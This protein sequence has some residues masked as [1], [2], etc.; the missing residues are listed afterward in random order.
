MA[1]VT[2][3][4]LSKRAHSLAFFARLI[5]TTIASGPSGLRVW[6]PQACGC[7][8]GAEALLAER[9][10]STSFVHTFVRYLHG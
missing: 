10:T 8:Y 5:F 6:E 4:F 9:E 1:L 3:G 2:R 7:R